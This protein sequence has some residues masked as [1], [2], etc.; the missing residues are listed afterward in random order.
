[1]WLDPLGPEGLFAMI[2]LQERLVLQRE[3]ATANVRIYFGIFPPTINWDYRRI[4]TIPMNSNYYLKKFIFNLLGV[5][6]Y[7]VCVCVCALAC[8]YVCV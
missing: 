4:A 1:M 5:F 2:P 3:V 6:V 7:Y 8:I